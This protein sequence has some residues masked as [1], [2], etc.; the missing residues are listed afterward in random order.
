MYNFLVS[1]QSISRFSSINKKS[2][3]NIHMNS[4][5]SRDG[6]NHEK[7]TFYW[8]WGD[9]DRMAKG[10]SKIE[11]NSTQDYYRRFE[12]GI[13]DR[14]VDVQSYALLTFSAASASWAP[15]NFLYI[16]AW[17]GLRMTAILWRDL[18]KEPADIKVPTSFNRFSHYGAIVYLFRKDLGSGNHFPQDAFV[19]LV[20]CILFDEK[21][22]RKTYTCLWKYK[23]LRCYYASSHLPLKVSKKEM[24]YIYF[25]EI[26]LFFDKIGS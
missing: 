24:S 20:F 23:F 19:C 22:E 9:K 17:I 8:C 18:I 25:L 3:R 26:L 12:L 21:T 16:F 6:E 14:E 10:P 13:R 2:G 15:I 7:T 11:K 4:L 1:C 5:Y